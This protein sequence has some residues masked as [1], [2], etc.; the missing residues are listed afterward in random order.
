VRGRLP[1][2]VLLDMDG[3]LVATEHVWFEVESAMVSGLGGSWGAADQAL[4]VGGPLE[5]TVE[6]MLATL[7][8]NGSTP[9]AA[10]LRTRLLDG[11]VARLRRGPVEWMPGAQRLLAEIAAADVPRALVSSSRRPVVDA[12]LDAIG[13]ELLP[14]TVSGDDVQRTKPHPDPY[15]LAARLLGVDPGACVA[16]EDSATGATSARAAGCLTIVV[17]GIAGVADGVADHRVGSLELLDLARLGE[18]ATERR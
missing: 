4:L 6:H 15:L 13:R 9:D 8:R 14:V 10:G 7:P 2:A 18:L 17:P 12:V 5:R 11:M 1:A 16:L 3:L